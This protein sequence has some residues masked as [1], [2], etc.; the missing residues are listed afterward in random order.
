MAPGAIAAP[1][2]I[3]FTKGAARDTISLARDDGTGAAFE[4]P[5][6]GPTPHDAYHFFVERELGLGRGF[7]GLV[8][9]GMDPEAVGAMAA[10]GGHASAK[11]ARKPDGEILELIQAERLVECFEA[12]SWSGA[13]DDEGIRLMALAGWEASHVPPL[14]LGGVALGKIRAEIA[15]FAREWGELP[16]GGSLALQWP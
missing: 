10:A 9:H 6:K 11:R 15:D 16:P 12:E 5:H 2:R 3:T 7:W 1:M 4:F 14:A 13:P 8:A